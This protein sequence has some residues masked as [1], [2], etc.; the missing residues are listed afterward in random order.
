MRTYLANALV[1]FISS[2]MMLMIV[3]CTQGSREL[4]A[5]TPGGTPLPPPEE[6]GDTAGEPAET[7]G[8]PGGEFGTIVAECFVAVAEG[9]FETAK[10]YCTDSFYEANIQ[11]MEEMP[12][13]LR[14]QM[15][16]EYAAYTEDRSELA[17]AKVEVEGSEATMTITE[18]GGAITTI[19]FLQVDGEWKI[20]SMESS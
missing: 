19:G 10:T 14:D 12:Q 11:P 7:A 20:N 15:S 9:N 1:I 2:L 4:P 6:N 17:D 3:S 13:E 16:Q 8:M 18:E 5:P